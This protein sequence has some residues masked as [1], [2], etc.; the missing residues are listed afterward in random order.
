ML[1]FTRFHKIPFFLVEFKGEYHHLKG[2]IKDLVILRPGENF[3]INIFNPENSSPIIHAERIFD[4]LKSGRFLDESGEFSPQMEKVLVEI[5]V[6]V[7][8]NKSYRSWSGFEEVCKEFLNSNKMKI[9]MLNQ[10]L[11]SIKNR[12][13]RFSNGP[14]K[15]IFE[16]EQGI[17]VTELFKSSYLLDLSSI[18]RLGGEKEDALFFLNMILKYLWDLNLTRG[19]HDYRGIKHIMI[20][21]DAQ[22]FAPKKLS[23]QSKLSSYLEDIALLQRGT[24]ECLITLAT[25]PDISEEILAN[26]GVLVTFKTHLEKDILRRLLNLDDDNER[27]LSMLNDGECIIRTHSLKRPFLLKIPFVKRKSLKYVDLP[28]KKEITCK[29]DSIQLKTNRIKDTPVNDQIYLSQPDFEKKFKDLQ[30]FVDEA[31]NSQEKNI[32]FLD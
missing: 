21:E 15:A 31:Y 11:I 8:Q 23:M 7:C 22:Y 1:N 18:I 32:K 16:G 9:P 27:Y 19:S 25:R 13:R 10:T 6:E 30:I 29:D 2:K 12:I 28:K 14:L 4:I 5:L 3:F 20:V 24:G 17:E 26:C